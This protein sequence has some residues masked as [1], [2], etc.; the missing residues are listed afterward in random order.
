M[1]LLTSRGAAVGDEDAFLEPR[2]SVVPETVLPVPVP[3]VLARVPLPTVSVTAPLMVDAVA[4]MRTA[5]TVS[6]AVNA[7]EAVTSTLSRGR[8]CRRSC[9]QRLVAGQGGDAA[10]G[11]GGQVEAGG[12]A[13]DDV[14]SVTV[15]P[16]M[17]PLVSVGAVVKTIWLLVEPR[18]GRA[19]AVKLTVAP[20][21]RRQAGEGQGGV[22]AAAGG[23]V[24]RGVAGAQR[25]GRRASPSRRRRLLPRKLSV[26]PLRATGAAS[27]TRLVLLAPVLSSVSVPPVLTVMPVMALRVPAPLSVSVPPLTVMVLVDESVAG[28]DAGCRC[29]S[30]RLLPAGTGVLDRVSETLPLMPPAKVVV[31]VARTSGAFDWVTAP[32]NVIGLPVK[33]TGVLLPLRATALASVSGAV[34]WTTPAVRV[35][36]PVPRAALL[37]DGQGADCGRTAGVQGDAGDTAGL[38][39]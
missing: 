30:G 7:V 5:L 18:S 14:A 20:A 35:S 10:G 22:L 3:P 21:L 37:P 39:R 16:L 4:A 25:S 38:A 29:C 23:D 1:V 11:V 15:P 26:P 27:L 34:A 17:M 12:V 13:G 8:R 2:A 6:V 24:D 19:P 28:E 36:V 32:V 9:G 33:A 31:L